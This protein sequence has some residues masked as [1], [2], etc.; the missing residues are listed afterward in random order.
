[1]F[2]RVGD[3]H[4]VCRWAGG[5]SENVE[6]ARSPESVHAGL[7]LL[8]CL[9]YYTR[10][11]HLKSQSQVTLFVT[12]SNSNSLVIPYRMTATAAAQADIAGCTD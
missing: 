4:D 10:A 5:F 1:M 3:G 7:I 9:Q 6:M 2:S 8:V 11:A 12:R